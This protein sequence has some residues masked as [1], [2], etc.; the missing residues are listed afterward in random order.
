MEQQSHPHSKQ[1][2]KKF[3]FESQGH[4]QIWTGCQAQESKGEAKRM[5]GTPWPASQTHMPPGLLCHIQNT[6]ATWG[7]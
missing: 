3:H 4:K 1:D 7:Y 2:S 6:L 5:A